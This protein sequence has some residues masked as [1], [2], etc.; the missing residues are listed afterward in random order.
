MWLTEVY[1]ER[2]TE[3]LG[4]IREGRQKTADPNGDEPPKN[5]P[6]ISKSVISAVG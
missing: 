4:Y 2:L 6:K 5:K 3:L 1:G